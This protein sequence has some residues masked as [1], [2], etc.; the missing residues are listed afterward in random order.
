MSKQQ[1][2]ESILLR[3]L[4]MLLFVLVWRLSELLLGMTVLLQLIY[5][6]CTGVVHPGLLRFG[7]SLTQY[8]AQI[9]RFGTF[10]AEA[11]PW[12]FAEWPAPGESETVAVSEPQVAAAPESAE[13]HKC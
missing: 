4:W 2:N 12:P 1:Q 3:T 6:L 10:N 13:Q 9:A 8:V 7:D 5:R 11:K